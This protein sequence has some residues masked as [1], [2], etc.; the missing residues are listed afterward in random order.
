MTSN[1][2]HTVVALLRTFGRGLLLVLFAASLTIFVVNMTIIIV[3]ILG[4]VI[5]L[6]TGTSALREAL[7]TCSRIGIVGIYAS[8]IVWV[9]TYVL[10]SR[11]SLRPRWME[12]WNLGA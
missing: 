1:K 2:G 4:R 11:P 8:I 7:M 5:A 12:R 3:M 9:A 6:L 10:Y